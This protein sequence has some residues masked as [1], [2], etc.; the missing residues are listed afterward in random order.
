MAKYDLALYILDH[1][2]LSKRAMSNL[3]KLIEDSKVDE[4]FN[5][6]IIDISDKPELAEQEKIMATPV[7]IKNLP[8]PAQRLIGDLS[9]NEKVLLS[10]DIDP[11]T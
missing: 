4:K 6:E 7:L 11:E 2:P 8:E 1:T 3:K 10:L 5:V 9:D